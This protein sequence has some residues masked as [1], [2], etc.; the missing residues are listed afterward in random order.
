MLVSDLLQQVYVDCL[1]LLLGGLLQGGLTV[2][3]VRGRA[4]HYFAHLSWLD[5]AAT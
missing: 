5:R 1:G 2:V 4:F 3:Y